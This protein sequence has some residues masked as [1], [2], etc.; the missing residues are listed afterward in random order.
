MP[1]VSKETAAGGHSVE[2]MVDDRSEELDG[3][4]VGFTSFACDI[5][6]TPLLKGL[7]GGQCQCP[8]WGYVFT[9]KIAFRF[10][11]REETYEAGDAYYVPPGHVP[12]VF[13]GTEILQFQPAEEMAKTTEV[14]ARNMQAMAASR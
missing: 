4:L 13:D 10:D 5:D 8:H 12:L 6:G 1:K 11:D 9:G 3:F 2:G 14:M 7:P